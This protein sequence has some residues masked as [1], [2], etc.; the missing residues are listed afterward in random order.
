LDKETAMGVRAVSLLAA[1]V[2][3][4]LAGSPRAS[5]ITS[6]PNLPA[7]YPGAA[8]R[9]VASQPDFSGVG[10]RVTFNGVEDRAS[11][12]V[13]RAPSGPNEVESYN[14]LWVGTVSVNLGPFVAMSASGPEDVVVFN[15]LGSATG[16][17]STELLG[18][19]LS[20]SSAYGPFLLRESPT[21]ASTGQTTITGLGGGLY[22]IDSFFDVFTE[23]SVDGGVTWIPSSG[24]T[25]VT[26]QSAPEPSAAGLLGAA[27]LSLAGLSR[28]RRSAR[29]RSDGP[30]G[31]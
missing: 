5:T 4:A 1:A 31:N 23:L 3:F 13:T 6:D 2:A 27:M 8:Y 24:P 11:G 21:I 9:Y 10:L 20:G 15:K 28:R 18:M 7:L 19:N 14:S 22:Q 17:F 16:T 12:P 25:R 26:L 30:D 29:R